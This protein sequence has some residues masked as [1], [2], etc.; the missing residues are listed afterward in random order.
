MNQLY[1][2]TQAVVLTVGRPNVPEAFEA[3]YGSLRDGVFANIDA[4]TDQEELAGGEPGQHFD[5]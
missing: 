3:E 4:N 1:R 5:W 2:A